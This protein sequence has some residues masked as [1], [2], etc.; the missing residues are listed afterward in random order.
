VNQNILLELA[1]LPVNELVGLGQVRSNGRAAIVFDLDAVVG[2]LAFEPAFVGAPG[3]ID[4]RFNVV[5][6]ECIRACH[7][8]VIAHK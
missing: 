5:Q 6:L 4:N 1:P 7:G 8:I 3:C 2:D